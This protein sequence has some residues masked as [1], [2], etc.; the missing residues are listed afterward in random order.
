M[1]QGTLGHLFF[2][3]S[4]SSQSDRGNQRVQKGFATMILSLALSFPSLSH[5]FSLWSKE[6]PA[7][8]RLTTHGLVLTQNAPKVLPKT[9][10]ATFAAGCFWGVE[11]EF[12]KQKGVIATAVGFMGGKTKNPTYEQVCNGNTGHAEVVQI[13]FDPTVI[14]YETL[15]DNYWFLH[16]PTTL[17]RQG[18]DVGDQYR[19]AIFY[20]SPEQKEAA[21][22]TRN[23]LLK[24]GEVDSQIVTQIVPAAEFTKADEYH[25]QYVEKGGHAGCHIRRKKKS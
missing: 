18:P 14:S 17:N 8:E 15:L 7:P 9:Q 3:S 19:S 10:L 1:S 2:Q 25:Q 4:H 12:R 24:A 20:H 5:A 22:A 23:Q 16:D 11:E 21:I 13:E 6:K